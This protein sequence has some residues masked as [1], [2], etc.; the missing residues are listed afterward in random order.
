[1]SVGAGVPTVVDPPVS[2]SDVRRRTHLVGVRMTPDEL[3]HAQA[4]AAAAGVGL[5]ELLRRGLEAAPCDPPVAVPCGVTQEWRTGDWCTTCNRST[6]VAVDVAYQGE[7]V[8]TLTGCT[9]CESGVCAP[10]GRSSRGRR[11]P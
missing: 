2:T 6:G 8:A 1:M 9:S 5:P 11:A 3:A 7:H 10:R 4:K